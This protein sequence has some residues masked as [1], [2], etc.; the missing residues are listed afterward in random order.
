M[1]RLIANENKIAA[2]VVSIGGT[3]APIIRSIAQYA[4]EFV[5]FFASQETFDQVTSIKT[6]LL[7]NGIVIMSEITI[8]DNVNDLLCCH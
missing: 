5:S 3:P 2:M 1:D 4:P 6:E 8:T 7:K